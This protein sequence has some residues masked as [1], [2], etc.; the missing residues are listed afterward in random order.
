[1]TFKKIFFLTLTSVFFSKA[2][3]QIELRSADDAIRI[4]EANDVER[5]LQKQS[6]QESVRLAKK[7]IDGFLPVFDFSFSDAAKAQKDIDDSKNKT[8]EF[9]VTQKVFNGGKTIFE[10]KMQRERSFYQFL[11]VLKSD[12][13]F[14]NTLTQCYYNALLQKLKS[15][16]LQKNCQNAE[17]II[18]AADLEAEEGMITKTE[19]LETLLQYRQM[20]LEA[21]KALDD[22]EELERELK[23]IMNIDRGQKIIFH[24]TEN[25]EMALE[26][27]SK[28]KGL[29]EKKQ[30][31]C[32][33]A[34]Q[35]SV[36]LKMAAAELA[37]AQKIRSMQ[38]RFFLPS[39]SIRGG[40]SFNGRN[41]P[42]TSPNYSL[43]VILAFEDNPWIK[44]S[45]S[46]QSGFSKGKMSSMAD[47][48]SAQ[49][50]ANTIFFNQMRLNKIEIAQKRFGVENAKKQIEE[51]IWE[52]LKKIENAQENFILNCESAKIKEEKLFVSKISLDQGRIKKSDFLEE[53]NEC[54]KQK[55]QCFSFLKERDYWSKELEAAAS[56]KIL[57]EER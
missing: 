44:S 33:S 9:G 45:V 13:K 54:A 56:I 25:F 49:L 48:I 53:M 38:K 43:K 19:Y 7:N 52:I 37:W 39:V 40:V 30:T 3:S 51:N 47:S 26:N 5:S 55:I 8:I 16:L 46:R 31:C 10:W 15:R 29:E 28:I 23:R 32:Q 57:E 50:E 35:N 4:A 42:L 1:M 6:A 21:K 14:K 27:R 22:F 36:D 34:I 12:Q 17:L 2:F 18:L 20:K 24:E 41:Y 11:S